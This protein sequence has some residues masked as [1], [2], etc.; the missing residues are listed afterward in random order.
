MHITEQVIDGAIVL[1]L[2]GELNFSSRK[3]FMTAI[4]H[5]A[6]SNHVHVIVDLQGITS[7]DDAAISL[8]V[9]AHQKLLHQHHRLSL[10]RPFPPLEEKLQSMKFPRIIPIYSSLNEALRRKMVRSPRIH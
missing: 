9:I 3:E 10:L 1:E 6:Q 8:L 5:A 2:G 7:T 4:Q